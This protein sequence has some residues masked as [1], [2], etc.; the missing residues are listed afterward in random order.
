M[1]YCLILKVIVITCIIIFSTTLVGLLLVKIF[2]TKLSEKR[3]RRFKKLGLLASALLALVFGFGV[4]V[5][6]IH[7]IMT[8]VAV[9]TARSGSTARVAFSSHPL[10][11]IL[12]ITIHICVIYVVSLMLVDVLKKYK[13]KEN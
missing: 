3:F 1:S 8:G 9:N 6:T 10:L 12:F 5:S 2:E 4:T 7:Q 13:S 11:F